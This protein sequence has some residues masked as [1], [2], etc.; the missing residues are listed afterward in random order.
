MY[1]KP[2]KDV[3]QVRLPTMQ[4]VDNWK[5]MMSELTRDAKIPDLFRMLLL[6][7]ICPKDV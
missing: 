5:G 3:G 1:P 6:R 2:A 7:E 4:W